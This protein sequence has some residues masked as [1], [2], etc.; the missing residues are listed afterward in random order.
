MKSHLR[1]LALVLFLTTSVMSTDMPRS[2]Q[3]QPENG[4]EYHSV[5]PEEG[6]D[7]PDTVD[8]VKV[9]VGADDLLPWI[10]VNDKLVSWT[11]EATSQEVAQLQDNAN[12]NRVTKL[13]LPPHPNKAIRSTEG[14]SAR[15]QPSEGKDFYSVF[16][17]VNSDISETADF[18]KAFVG[19][20]DLLP[21][22]DLQGHL[23]SWTVELSEDES[24]DLEEHPG[25]LRAARLQLPS[26]AQKKARRDD[27][28]SDEDKSYLIIPVDGTDTQQCANTEHAL[29][30]LLKDQIREPYFDDGSL[31]WW[32]ATTMTTAEAKQVEGLPGVGSV[33]FNPIMDDNF[34]TPEV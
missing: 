33:E 18:V 16:P 21:W 5:F 7:T 32:V 20:D 28:T 31:E 14:D 3:S 25:I 13:Q 19:T 23:I 29:R 30:D 34:I 8:F 15:R 4:R 11:V 22:T 26:Q 10:N 1:I 17:I 6:A 27:S 2:T 9:T 24:Y 12:I